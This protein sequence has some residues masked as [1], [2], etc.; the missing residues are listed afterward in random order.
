MKV[1]K[2]MYDEMFEDDE[3]D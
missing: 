3:E 2:Q 1:S